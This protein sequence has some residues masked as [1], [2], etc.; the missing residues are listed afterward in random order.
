[1]YG[2][3]ASTISSILAKK[4]EIKEADVA[5]GVI[6]LTKQRSQTIKDV[7]K[8]LLVWIN[9]QQLAGD[10][11]SEAIICE[12]ARLLHEDLAKKMPGMS[13]AVSEFKASRGWF[14]KFKKQTS[15]HSVVRQ[16]ESSI[17]V[18]V[19]LDIHLSISLVI[20]RT[21]LQY[22]CPIIRVICLTSYGL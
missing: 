9:K 14:D 15:I 16:Q 12:K 8:L 21:T 22:E 11:V 4:K 19:M 18:K 5:K 13:A 1:M 2:K 17:K 3:S 6:V 10:S 7:E 20:Y